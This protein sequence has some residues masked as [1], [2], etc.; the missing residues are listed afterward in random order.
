MALD[1]AASLQEFLPIRVVQESIGNED[2][3]FFPLHFLEDLTFLVFFVFWD[4]CDEG[5]LSLIVLL[6]GHGE[7]FFSCAVFFS[8]RAALELIFSFALLPLFGMVGIT[9]INKWKW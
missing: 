5:F 8:G 7:G 1:L 3:L 4:G 6:S 9:I 2:D